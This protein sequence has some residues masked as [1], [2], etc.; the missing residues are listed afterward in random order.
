MIKVLKYLKESA[1]VILVIVVLLTIQAICDISL[2]DYTAKIVNVG[3]QQG[4][5]EHASPEIVRKT[6]MD[7][8]LLLAGEKNEKQILSNYTLLEKDK[9]SKSDYNKYHADYPLLAKEPLYH[10]NNLDDKKLDKLNKIISQPELLLFGIETGS[11]QITAMTAQ[12][13]ASMPKG[14]LPANA[15]FFDILKVL[16]KEQQAKMLVGMNEK[17]SAMPE[18]MVEQASVKYV[19]AEYNAIGMNTD[20]LQTIYILLAGLW[21]LLLTLASV[22]AAIIVTLLSSKVAARLGMNLRGRVFNKVVSFSNDEFDKFSTASLITRSTNDIQQVQ[23]L[24]VWF[25]RIAIY[26]PI[27]AIGGVYKVFQT[28]STMS[29]IIGVAVL[30]VLSLMIV[31]FSVAIPRF[32]LLQKL[33]DKLN[34]V[35]REILTGL[36]VIRAFH[37]EKHEE[38]RFDVTN[39]DLTR[40]NLFVNRVMTIMMPTMMLIMNGVALLIIWVGAHNI[41]TGEMQV[42][43]M[44]AFIAYTMQ[45]IMAFIMISM[46]SIMLPRAS[47]SAKRI[48]EVLDTKATINDPK[49]AKLFDSAKKGIVEFK[50]VSFRYHGAG[51][52]VLSN[53]NFTALPGKTTAIIGSTGSGKSTLIHLIP[54]F[55]DV[56]DGEI[57]VDGVNIKEVKQHD[58]RSKIG[59]VPQ[60][61]NLFSGTIESNIK[62]GNTKTSDTDM[63][64][65]ARIAQ[66]TDFINEKPEKYASDISQGGSNVSGGQR[67]RLAIAR[68]I[69]KN[70]EIYIFD[71]SF[72][73]L[74]YKTDATLR[75]ALSEETKE[76]AVLIVAQR[77]ST[78]LHADQIIVLDE[79]KIVGCGTHNELMKTCE[80]YIQIATSQLSKEELENESK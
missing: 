19:K 75:Q 59:F 20:H 44:M 66:A 35:S 69:A 10:L 49:N 17:I 26:A 57:L 9:L 12:L 18:S 77:I 50:N 68:A 79:G 60:K 15:T 78:I 48:A 25:L 72:S 51:E 16:P 3:I 31:L 47:V 22:I 71:D 28:N 53:I 30:A 4:G 32:R 33:V 80:V 5:I 74:D 34:L 11:K 38:A 40:T 36:P 70:P 45:I 29:W 13:K 1:F 56:T 43:D 58:L 54:R 14:V 8:I 65:A 55:Y 46:I 42:G 27:I 39:K 23:M 37:N 52:D 41:N 67:Q 76:A 21:M 73:A 62:F 2:P 24:M 6:E 64:K 61:G 7:K 63:E